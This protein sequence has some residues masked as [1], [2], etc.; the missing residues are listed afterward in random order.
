MVPAHASFPLLTL[1]NKL[2]HAICAL[3]ALSLIRED[4]AYRAQASEHYRIA[5]E[6]Q[7]SPDDLLA[8]NVLLRNFLLLVYYMCGGS[9]HHL[10]EQTQWADLLEPL[11][12]I[13]SLRSQNL[14]LDRFAYITWT[15]AR[16]DMYAC[17]LGHGNC[18][19]FRMLVN[20]RILPES[21]VLVPNPGESHDR[22]HT[23][24]TLLHQGATVVCFCYIVLVNSGIIALTLSLL[25]RPG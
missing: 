19:F 25:R 13:V 5:F 11:C 1:N 9:T 20:K 14:Q 2:Y 4:D 7:P 21:A 17:L 10:G 3:A 15:T 12:F 18:S 6:A 23:N 8:D 22:R 16:M 24:L